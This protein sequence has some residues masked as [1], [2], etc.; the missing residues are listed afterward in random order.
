MNRER[1]ASLIV[2]V[3]TVVCT[4]L[5]IWLLEARSAPAREECVEEKAREEVRN[6]ALEGIDAGFKNHVELLFEVWVKDPNEQPRR[7]KVGMQANISAYL[8][9]RAD[10]LKWNPPSC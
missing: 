8:R 10:A 2:G 6:L 4:L 3:T 1:W 9:A 5:I 7:A